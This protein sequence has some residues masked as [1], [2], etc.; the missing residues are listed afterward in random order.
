MNADNNPDEVQMEF[1]QAA[2][3]PSDQTDNLFLQ[4]D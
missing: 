3:S 4:A 2:G 1:G